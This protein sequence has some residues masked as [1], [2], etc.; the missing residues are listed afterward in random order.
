MDLRNQFFR[1]YVL[2]FKH[3]LG[4]QDWIWIQLSWMHGETSNNGEY[5]NINTFNIV[6]VHKKKI[7]RKISIKIEVYFYFICFYVTT[8]QWLINDESILPMCRWF[9]TYW[10]MSYAA[11]LDLWQM[12]RIGMTFKLTKTLFGTIYFGYI[13]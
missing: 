11:L 3:S 10:T 7:R 13:S 9:W 4:N 8:C 12:I 2:M 5:K 6:K 1:E